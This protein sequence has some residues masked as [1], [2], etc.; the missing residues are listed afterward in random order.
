M[1]SHSKEKWRKR[2]KVKRELNKRIKYLQKLGKRQHKD[3][4]KITLQFSI[5]C[6][7]PDGSHIDMSLIRNFLQRFH[8]FKGSKS[9]KIN[10]SVSKG[11]I[12]DS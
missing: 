7:E 4:H 1:A 2:E 8:I 12:M 10:R 5:P 3:I 6:S 9:K 11:Q